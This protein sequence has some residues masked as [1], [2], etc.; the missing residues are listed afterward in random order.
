[1][2]KAKIVWDR[3][4]DKLY[5]GFVD[6]ETIYWGPKLEIPEVPKEEIIR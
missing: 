3:L 5:K 2:L 4:E 1:M 6:S